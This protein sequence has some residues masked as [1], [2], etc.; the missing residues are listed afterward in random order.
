VISLDATVRQ[1]HCERGRANHWLKTLREVTAKRKA[2]RRP[3][4]LSIFLMCSGSRPCGQLV[5][6]EPQILGQR[7]RMR[8]RTHSR[9]SE[10]TSGNAYSQRCNSP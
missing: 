3:T 9:H 6:P 10:Q 4:R 5:N 8:L 1:L 2:R 7:S